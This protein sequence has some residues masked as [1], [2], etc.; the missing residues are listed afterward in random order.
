MPAE[1]RLWYT[2]RRYFGLHADAATQ[3]WAALVQSKAPRAVQW[4]RQLQFYDA[5]PQWN[6]QPEAIQSYV[7][8]SMPP[9]VIVHVLED[10]VEEGLLSRARATALQEAVLERVD[11][12]GQWQ[13]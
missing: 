3:W 6:Q 13:T 1:P 11:A 10:L 2:F 9:A 5:K 7:V 12:A 4:L 8:R